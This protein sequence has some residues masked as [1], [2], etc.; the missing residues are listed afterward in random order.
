ML[1][2]VIIACMGAIAYMSKRQN[3]S[4]SVMLKQLGEN[5]KAATDRESRLAKRIDELDDE[6]RR[7]EKDHATQL[8][9]LIKEV[10]TAIA[11]A[12]QERRS[13]CAELKTLCR[14]LRTRPCLCEGMDEKP[15][16]KE[17]I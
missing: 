6:L 11:E 15:V 9:T 14:V 16:S 1:A 4:S 10:T 8:M 12:N 7:V 2:I 17:T 5:A 13:L 3:D